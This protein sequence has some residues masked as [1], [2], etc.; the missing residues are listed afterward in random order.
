MNL[1][2]RLIRHELVSGSFYIFLGTFS[3]NI[4]A[5]LLNLFLAR[6]LT[7]SDYAIYASLLSVITLAAVPANS[8]NTIIVKYATGF[9]A[10]EKIGELKSF[11]L[12]FLKVIILMSVLIIFIFSIF[13]VPFKN[14]LRI[15]NSGY[16]VI[17]GVVIVTLYF[18]MLNSAYLQSLL[19]FKFLSFSVTFGGLIKILTGILFVFLGFRAFSGL[20][21]IIFMAM[22]TFLIA[23]VP[24]INILKAKEIKIKQLKNEMLGGYVFSTFVTVLFLTSFTSSD[25]ILVKH[26]F[27]PQMAGFYSG[28]SL[29]GKVIFYFTAPI[30]MV[31]FPILIKRHAMGRNFINT[32]YLSLFLV[33]LPSVAISIFYFLFPDF[34]IKLFL[35]GRDYLFIAKY[36]GIFGLNLTI[37]SLLNVCINFFLSLGRT[38]IVFPVTVAA[39]LQIILIYVYHGNFYQVIGVS[40][41]VSVILMV[42]LV[43]GFLKTFG[44]INKL[45]ET[46]SVVNSTT[47]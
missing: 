47:V 31:M 41:L 35:G 40:M 4:L 12:F 39:I 16:I 37:F 14:Y 30:S 11:Y 26:F 38:K 45:K 7:Y 42:I 19:K 10:K 24:L 13:S 29:I 36:L 3:S 20:Y 5:F 25:V 8:L 21:A 28:M 44:N 46:V 17:S 27:S 18:N 1:I 32:F 15:D 22:G 34:V 9:F 23:F 2:N 6:N 33:F 43:I